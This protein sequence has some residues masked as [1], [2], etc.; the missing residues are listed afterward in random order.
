MR[1]AVSFIL[2]ALLAQGCGDST[3]AA[4]DPLTEYRLDI[5]TEERPLVEDAIE[6]TNAILQDSVPIRLQAGW[7]HSDAPDRVPV[8]LIGS[9]NVG[10]DQKVWIPEGERFVLINQPALIDFLGGV[11]K[12][13]NFSS[14]LAVILLHEIGHVVNGDVGSY[15][16]GEPL[17]KETLNSQSTPSKNRELAA[18]RFAASQLKQAMKTGATIPRFSA[19]MKVASSLVLLNFDVFSKRLLKHFGDQTNAA[20]LD[21]GYSHP[22]FELRLLIVLNEISPTPKSQALIEDFLGQR[23][24]P[25][26]PGIL[27]DS[28]PGH[29]KPAASRDPGDGKAP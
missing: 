25:I 6:R 12:R 28:R 21:S 14:V 16:G 8:Y 26:G 1:F 13:E 27:F 10:R 23:S 29:S 5:A 19:G 7:R 24:P 22:N 11:T 2:L 17:S 18:D 3:P 9:Y 20:Y 4:P 15:I